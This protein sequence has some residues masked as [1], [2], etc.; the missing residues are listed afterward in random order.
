MQKYAIKI[1]HITDTACASTGVYGANY[2]I[3][4]FMSSIINSMVERVTKLYKKLFTYGVW[5]GAGHGP[6]GKGGCT[7]KNWYAGNTDTCT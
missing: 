4:G 3:L 1:V 5:C 7:C 6:E 2:F